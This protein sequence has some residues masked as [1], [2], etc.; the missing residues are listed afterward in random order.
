MA[1]VNFGEQKLKTLFMR[2][3]GNGW[4]WVSPEGAQFFKWLQRISGK[5]SSAMGLQSSDR[6]SWRRRGASRPGGVSSDR[7]I[8]V[9]APPLYAAPRWI[10]SGS[11]FGCRD[12]VDFP[13]I[14]H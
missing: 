9:A 14:I 10:R 7:Q 5:P 6:R 2:A 13:G 12:T 11:P 3:Q 1:W 8:V 4:F